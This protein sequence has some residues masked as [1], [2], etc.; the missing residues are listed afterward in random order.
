MVTREAVRTSS[1]YPRVTSTVGALARQCLS[2]GDH[3][4]YVRQSLLASIFGRSAWER[5]PEPPVAPSSRGDYE[6]RV[7]QLS[8]GAD[9]ERYIRWSLERSNHERYARQSL[10]SGEQA[11]IT[12]NLSGTPADDSPQGRGPKNLV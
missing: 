8:L 3:E 5:A 11:K 4:R 2:S 12:N 1:L 10:L 6:L 7:H 9:H